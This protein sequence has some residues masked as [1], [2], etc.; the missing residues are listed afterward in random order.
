MMKQQMKTR[1]VTSILSAAAVWGT[2]RACRRTG[3]R[4]I[5][6]PI[7]LGGATFRHELNPAFMGERG[8]VTM[9]GLEILLSMRRAHRVWATSFVKLERRVS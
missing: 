8:Y 5:V 4:I 7:F 2:C 9:P 3:L 1:V 6:P